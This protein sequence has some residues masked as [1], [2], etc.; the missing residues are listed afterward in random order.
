MAYS[1]AAF[2]KMVMRGIIKGLL[3]IA[4]DVSRTM[5]SSECSL[6]D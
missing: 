5:I 6:Q 3:Y 4:R 1:N 2:T